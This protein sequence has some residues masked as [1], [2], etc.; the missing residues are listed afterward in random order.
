[1]DSAVFILYNLKRSR[2]WKPN[3]SDHFR[4][5]GIIMKKFFCISLLLVL[6]I[7]AVSASDFSD[8]KMDDFF[9]ALQGGDY[10]QGIIELLTG[11]VLEEKVINEDETLSNWISQ[12]TQIRSI[13][14][15]YL[16]YEKAAVVSLGSLEETTYFVH[17]ID[18]PIQIVI[19]EYNNGRRKQLVNMFFN[20]EVLET[21]RQL[22]VTGR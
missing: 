2:G 19:T 18:Y 13:Y 12:F 21:M 17:C 16:G 20:D 3:A 4:L 15:D 14:G 7:F 10:R 22:G 11:S 8:R 1:M 6:V 5:E 9:S